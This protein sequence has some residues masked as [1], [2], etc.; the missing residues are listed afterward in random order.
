MGCY[1]LPTL[2]GATLTLKAYGMKPGAG[3]VAGDDIID[4]VVFGQ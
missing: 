3:G 1:V 2:Q 4:S